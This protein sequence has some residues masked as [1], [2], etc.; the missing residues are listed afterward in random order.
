MLWTEWLKRGRRERLRVRDVLQQRRRWSE[1][2]RGATRTRPGSP[3][4]CLRV[5]SSRA[6]RA[7]S[8]R[9]SGVAAAALERRDEVDRRRASRALRRERLL[10]P[11]APR[12]LVLDA[13]CPRAPALDADAHHARSS[14]STSAQLLPPKPNDVLIS[15][16]GAAALDAA[17][18]ASRGASAGDLGIA[19]AVPAMRRQRAGDG[20]RG[21]RAPA[22]RRPPRS[23][24]TRR[25]HDR[26]AASSS[27]TAAPPE[28]AR[29]RGRSRRCRSA[30]SPCRGDS[31]RRSAPAR[32][33]ASASASRMQASE[34]RPSGSG[35][36]M[37]W[38]SLDSPAP[39]SWM[40]PR[41]RVNQEERP[42]LAEREAVAVA[43]HRIRDARA[44][45]PAT[46]RSPAPSARRRSRSRPPRRR[47]RDRARAA[48]ARGA[49]RLRTGRAGRRDRV[50]GT[51]RARRRAR[52]T[53]PERRARAARARSPRRSGPSARARG[54]PSSADAMPDVLVPTTTPSRCAPMRSRA[55]AT[56]FSICSKASCASW[57]LRQARS[58]QRR[59][60][61]RQPA[62]ARVRSAADAPAARSSRS[63]TPERVAVAEPRPHLVQR[64][65]ERADDADVR[66]AAT[67]DLT[68]RARSRRLELAA[69]QLA[70]GRTRQRV[71]ELEDARNLVVLD[72]LAQEGAQRVRA[73]RS[74]RRRHDDRLQARHRARDTAPAPR[75]QTRTAGC[76]SSADSTSSGFTLR[77]PTS[78]SSATR[79]V[80]A[81]RPLGV[82]AAEVA[83][84]EEAVDQRALRA[85]RRSP[86]T[87]TPRR[88][89]RRLRRRRASGRAGLGASAARMRICT[90]ASGGPT[91]SG[92]KSAARG[93]E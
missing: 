8:M 86:R 24:P 73:R 43:A 57:L 65:P 52:R 20:R 21:A 76:A 41:S 87:S 85:R 48:N 74:P 13:R 67:A 56:R 90:S 40:P 2:D 60:E 91:E 70:G 62:R 22:S 72:P 12:A 54:T 47:R 63:A 16:A 79:P 84:E 30:A 61:L 6:R 28:D 7:S 68:S 25:A 11:G 36:D 59:G 92:R 53:P 35:A 50:G 10:R 51:L 32:A 93:S 77:P 34:P 83:G 38:A 82:D 9:A 19:L 15:A 88:R 69:Q 29:D 23:R 39:S 18:R 71:P 31:G 4:S 64:A 44:R 58:P 5:R 42:A 45:S 49:E 78:I 14:P 66:R 75:R 17:R 37:W 81:R 33:P 80:S 89:R 26:P 46:R 1:A 27:C 3:P 55:A